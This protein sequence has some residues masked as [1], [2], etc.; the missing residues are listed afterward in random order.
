[1]YNL[2][3]FYLNGRGVERDFARA[4]EHYRRAAD[5]GHERAM[6]LVGRCMEEGWGTGRDL[7]A[8]AGW[9]R[10]SAEAGYFR[11]Q[12]NWATI[13][14]NMRRAGEAAMWLERA[15]A[16]G[17]AAVRRAVQDLLGTLR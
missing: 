16:G 2:G 13:L 3:H 10:R 7:T 1:L 4:Y 12:Y 6:N 15:A 11:G 17:T 8:A 9:Y 14:L 5:Q